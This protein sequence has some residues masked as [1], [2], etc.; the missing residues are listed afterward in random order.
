[1]SKVSEL[2]SKLRGRAEQV[3]ANE[4]LD[5]PPQFQAF[6]DM[7]YVGQAHELLVPFSEDVEESFHAAHQREYGHALRDREVEIVNLRLRA[8]GAVEPL[9]LPHAERIA[10]SRPAPISS[11]IDANGNTTHHFDRNKFKPGAQIKGPALVFQMDCTTYIAE[12]WLAHVDRYH[13]LILE[14]HS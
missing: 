13:N 9:E 8:I 6:V 7:R 3:L 4:Q 1:M 10:V 2:L 11:Q 12:G 5:E 14:R